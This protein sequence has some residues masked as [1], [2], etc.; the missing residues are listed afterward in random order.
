MWTV[1]RISRNL[2]FYLDI[3][4]L[5]TTCRCDAS[6]SLF[7]LTYLQF[8]LSWRSSVLK[9]NKLQRAGGQLS[10]VMPE[11]LLFWN[12]DVMGDWFNS[13]LVESNAILL[14]V[15]DGKKGGSKGIVRSRLSHLNNPNIWSAVR[16]LV[17]ITSIMCT[18]WLVVCILF[19]ILYFHAIDIISPSGLVVCILF[20]ILFCILYF[21]YDFYN[22]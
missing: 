12:C 10:P 21:V 16:V 19:C 15:W 18:S 3:Y 17:Y 20:C 13:R 14:R 4:E 6:R 22:K 8:A 5:K 1:L 11:A 2:R 7:S 9:Q